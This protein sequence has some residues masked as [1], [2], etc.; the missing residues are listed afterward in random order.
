VLLAIYLA[1]GALTTACKNNNNNCMAGQCDTV[2]GTE[3]CMQ[4]NQGKVP[5]NGLCVDKANAQSKCTDSAGTGVSDQTCEK[6]A[7]DSFM[8][9]GGCYDTTTEPGKSMCETVGVGKCTVAKPGYF[10]PLEQDAAYQSVIPCGD[11]SVVT[12]KGGK[13]YKGVL[14]CTQC[15][16]PSANAGGEA[17]SAVCNT[18][19]NGFFVQTTGNTKTCEACDG[20]CKTCSGTGTN[21]CTACTA[22]THFLASAT[23]EG[24]CVSCGTVQSTW[25]GVA[26]CAKCTKPSDANTPAVCT[27]CTDSYYLKTATG[28]TPPSCVGASECGKGLFPTT[29]SNIKTCISCSTTANGGITDCGECS[30]LPSASGSSTTLITCMKCSSGNL[31][32]LKNECMTTCPAG[33][34]AKDNICTPC[35]ASC[36]ECTDDAE[37]SCTACYPGRVLNK[38]ES[39]NTGT[40]IPE[41][42]GRY[43]ENCAD[44][45]CTAVLGGSK[46]CSKCKSG[47]VPVDGLCVLTTARAPP[48]GCTPN[49]D[50]TCSACT[51]T[52][53]KE[54]G[55]CYKAGA[56][57]GN[58][59]CTTA[60][61]GSCTMCVSSGQN[62]QGQS[63]PTCP[64]GCSKCS[65]NSGSETCSE[66]FAGYYK[67]SA[68]TCVKCSE[69]S[70]GITGVPNCVSCKEPSGASGT[71][72]CYV[73][74]TPAVDPADPSV[75]KGGLSSGAIAGISVAVIVVV[76]GLV[77][78]LC[79]W[80]VC[81]GK[82]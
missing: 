29:V 8:F 3:I 59:I 27:E 22:E 77:G 39:L 33:T 58:A 23:T 64:V 66:C 53:F 54:S 16:A 81:R 63:C 12:V 60:T 18:C 57:P 21:K 37:S 32:P 46:Y 82:A 35:H 67:T 72:T 71:V 19:E 40:C 52:Y 49:N 30:L 13:K 75:N 5:V 65:G 80:F 25:S 70:N 38:T 4:C 14:H 76:G 26:N 73:T 79:W 20:T 34:Y 48:T 7:G 15:Q 24:P 78:F 56:F 55:G 68:N 47:F 45:Q 2:A 11:D 62:P 10:V 50:G 51:D 42:T 44:G 36:S 17:V 6:C 41:C 1:A 9:K 31:S 61:G 69:N 43:A 74:Q 28:A